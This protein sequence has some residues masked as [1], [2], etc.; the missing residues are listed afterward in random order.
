MQFEQDNRAEFWIFAN[1]GGLVY[2]A[3]VAEKN[4]FFQRKC[5]LKVERP[6]FSSSF[7]ILGHIECAWESGFINHKSHYMVS[8]Y[9]IW[10]KFS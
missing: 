10:S 3:M 5:L 2:Q 1:I 9:I 4:F 6:Y 8:F 7:L